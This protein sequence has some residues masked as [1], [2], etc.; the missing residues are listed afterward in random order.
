MRHE[1]N[2]CIKDLGKS[3]KK[4]KRIRTR[5]KRK[6]LDKNVTFSIIHLSITLHESTHTVRQY[7]YKSANHIP[8]SSW[9]NHVTGISD[10][11]RYRLPLSVVFSLFLFPC[12]RTEAV[13]NGVHQ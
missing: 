5:I 2:L 10:H 1:A 4:R 12:S 7:N 6:R 8:E 13:S 11:L 9:K 3:K